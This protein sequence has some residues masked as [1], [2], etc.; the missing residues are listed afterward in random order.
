MRIKGY[1]FVF[2]V[3]LIPLFT[4]GQDRLFP[5]SD[6][7][8][9]GLTNE[10]K[11]V[12]AVPQFDARFFFSN[13]GYALVAK[14]KKTGTL[15]PDGKIIISCDY[16]ILFNVDGEHGYGQM[17]DKYVLLNFKT[18]QQRPSVVFDKITQY[19]SACQ[20]ALL[21]VTK[22][23]KEGFASVVTGQPIG[24]INYDYAAF[25]AEF[26]ARGLVGR[27]NKYGMVDA[28]T[29]KLLIPL[30]YDKLE[31]QSLHDTEVVV[32]HSGKDLRYFD[33]DGKEIR[34]SG[35][36][37]TEQSAPEDGQVISAVKMEGQP[38]QMIG[39]KDPGA[40][41]PAHDND[42]LYVYNQ[43]GGNWQLA[44]ERRQYGH[45]EI[46]KT[47]SL[48][49]YSHLV[50]LNYAIYNRG[51]PVAVKAVKDGKAGLI[52]PSGKVLLPFEYD[53]ID[54]VYNYF[55]TYRDGK[56][57]LV[58]PDFSTCKQPALKAI[59]DKETGLKAWLVELPGGQKGYM[60]E[61]SGKIYI[62]GIQD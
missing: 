36:P 52:D 14:D 1:L 10:K 49:G 45:T 18:G 59:L 24:R 26:K 50:I 11:E 42:N 31:L 2:L 33:E 35:L 8:K 27:N 51:K 17:K 23:G 48:S 28:A 41:S 60:D 6:G 20:P 47:F 53:D 21:R 44:Y 43:G 30:K 25:I 61:S 57:G 39:I 32:A 40:T 19:C 9:W 12:L 13:Q 56:T 46:L 62:P 16:E 7:Q 4:R 29:G 58:N 38:L 22:G 15:A 34:K 5:Y 3:P 55:R 37:S 54:Y